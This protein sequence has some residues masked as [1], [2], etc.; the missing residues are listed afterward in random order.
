MNEEDD[1]PRTAQDERRRTKHAEG[2]KEPIGFDPMK[3]DETEERN[4]RRWLCSPITTDENTLPKEER[5]INN[6]ASGRMPKGL[7]TD[8]LSEYMATT[9]TASLQESRLPTVD[10][11]TVDP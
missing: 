11:T 4:D 8:Q 9:P 6:E 10:P 3:S 2:L 7:R 1:R 5:S